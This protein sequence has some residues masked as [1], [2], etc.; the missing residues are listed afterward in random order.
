MEK[1]TDSV[2]T[3]LDPDTL[4][5]VEMSKKRYAWNLVVITSPV[6]YVA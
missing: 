2:A 1:E 6:Q 5:E 3:V 4:E